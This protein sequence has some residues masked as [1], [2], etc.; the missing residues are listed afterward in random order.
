MERR[1]FISTLA[2]RLLAAPP[3]RGRP[4]GERGPASGRSRRRGAALPSGPFAQPRFFSDLLRRL[5]DLVDALS[6]TRAH[7][8][9]EVFEYVERFYNAS[10]G[11]LRSVT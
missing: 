3:A 5:Q 11:I 8:Q 9:G 1:T 2:G 10:G 6:T 7:A 4:Y